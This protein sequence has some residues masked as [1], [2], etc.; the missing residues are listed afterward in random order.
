MERNNKYDDEYL[1]AGYLFY[2]MSA[3]I[4]AGRHFNKE[5]DMA[6]IYKWLQSIWKQVMQYF[7]F[8]GAGMKALQQRKPATTTPATT[9]PAAATPAAATPAAATPAAATPAAP[10]YPGL[11][12]AMRKIIN[13]YEKNNKRPGCYCPFIISSRKSSIEQIKAS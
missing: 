12:T 1:Q 8:G 4:E 6:A 9:T 3:D 7:N 10:V 13:G 5:A 2:K 11:S